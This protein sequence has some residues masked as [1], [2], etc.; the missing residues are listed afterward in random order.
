MTFSTPLITRALSR[1]QFLKAGFA[2]ASCLALSPLL[3]G[4][5]RADMLLAPART[6]ALT[7]LHTGESCKLVYWE[8]GTYVPEAL[9]TISRV[10][11]DHRND[12]QYPMDV[13]LLNLLTALQTRL[14]T[15]SPFEVI[16]GYRSPES[17]AAMHAHS[18]GVASKS[19]HMEGKAIDIRMPGR[20]LANLH[21]TALTMGI[22]GVGYYPTSNFVH[23]DT[24]RVRQWRGA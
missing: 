13:T 12:A 22:G 20:S 8:Q 1:R 3:T 17:N 4:T 14:E 18:A 24:G 10:L 21:N 16:S 11:R 9:A 2:T 15:T 6:L 5:A 7:N 19:L 23:V